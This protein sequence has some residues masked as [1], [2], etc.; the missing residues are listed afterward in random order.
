MDEAY[1][2]QSSRYPEASR[3]RLTMD[4]ASR[5]G[6]FHSPQKAHLESHIAILQ[7]RI[8]ACKAELTEGWASAVERASSLDLR[9]KSVANSL[10]HWD[11]ERT[12]Y[13]NTF[14]KL[15]ADKN[16]LTDELSKLQL[17]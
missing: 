10:K 6:A 13:R 8:D 16:I 17:K 2:T 11:R 7:S 9:V 15:T 4:N 1:E 14:E 3:G 12:D 5:S